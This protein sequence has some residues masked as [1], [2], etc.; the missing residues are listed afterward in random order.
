MRILAFLVD[1]YADP[2][3][4]S[5]AG[6]NDQCLFLQN[7][8]RP[9]FIFAESRDLFFLK[10]PVVFLRAFDAKSGQTEIPGRE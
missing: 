4:F 1:L 8:E 2:C 7:R 9:V 10:I 6:A 5:R 3:D